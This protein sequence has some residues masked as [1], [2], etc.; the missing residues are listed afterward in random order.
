MAQSSFD[1][2]RHRWREVKGEPGLSYK[3]RHDYTILGYDLEAGTLDM[4]VRWAGDG[5]HCP[6]HR[7]TATTTVLVLEGEQHLW[8]LHADGS[9]GE[10]R[11]R[12]AGDYALTVGDALPH[13]ERG[14]PE[15]GLAFF[16]NHSENGRLYEILDEDMNV[17]LDVTME[18]L[19]EDW[20]AN[21]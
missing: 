5:G 1:P 6:L 7:H 4:V 21:S 18:T 19:V 11:V 2:G 12:R 20:K 9:R 15:G 8:D 16:G 10:H 17:V 14:G 3:V 13:L